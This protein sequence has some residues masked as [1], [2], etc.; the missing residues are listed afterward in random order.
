MSG[1]SSSCSHIRKTSHPL[2]V[3]SAALDLSLCMLRSNLRRQNSAFVAGLDR[4]HKGQACQKQPSTN[5]ATRRWGKTASGLPGRS[6]A[7]FRQPFT[8]IP[9]SIAKSL[10]SALVF[11][12]LTACI[13][14][15]RTSGLKLSAIECLEPICLRRS[16]YRLVHDNSSSTSQRL[17]CTILADAPLEMQSVCKCNLGTTY[18]EAELPPKGPMARAT[19]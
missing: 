19:G 14:R 5:I 9:A 6:D 12:P 2:A 18:V 11:L 4:L 7:C 15:R 13:A 1:D 3:R 16:D 17:S 8:C 10:R